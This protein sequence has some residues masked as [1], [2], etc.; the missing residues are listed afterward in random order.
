[1]AA[2]GSLVVIINARRAQ[3]NRTY[4]PTPQS[5]ADYSRREAAKREQ[6]QKVALNTILK[7]YD[8]NKSK[9]LERPQIIQL[10][11]DIDIFTPEGTPPTEEEVDWI[12]KAVDQA[13]DQCI[14]VG[15]L[16]EAMVCWWTYVEKRD[17][18]EATLAKYDVSQTGNLSK[19]ELKSY[20]VDLNGGMEVTDVE[21]EMVMKVADVLGNGTIDKMDLQRATA[22]WYAYVE[23]EKKGCCCLL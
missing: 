7:R 22:E 4:E 23:K 10:L 16:Q 13:G 9:K 5:R 6:K 17:E 2:P 12:I 18:L 8:T 19:G 20:L 14:D 15:E 11:T 3:G 21:L 1:M